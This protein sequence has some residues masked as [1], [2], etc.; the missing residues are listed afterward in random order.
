[1]LSLPRACAAFCGSVGSSKRREYT[2]IGNIV[3]L[4]ARLMQNS[5]DDILCEKNT[6]YNARDHIAFR[7]D[8]QPRRL[9]GF[10]ELVPVFRP[11]GRV[12]SSTLSESF[13][14]R[15]PERRSLAE[16]LHNLIRGGHGRTVFIEGDAGIG[17]TRLALHL[18]LKAAAQ[19]V[20]V[21][22][23]DGNF[24]SRSSPYY[25]WR[26]VFARIFSPDNTFTTHD[27]RTIGMEQAIAEDPEMAPLLPLLNQI[28]PKE[29]PD[30]P[31][32]ASLSP[33]V[34]ADN[35]RLFMIAVL[36]KYIEL[37]S[38]RVL[39]IFDDAHF[40][41]SSSIALCR[42]LH[43]HLSDVLLLLVTRTLK[44]PKGSNL[45]SLLRD[46][47]C[48]HLL[49]SGLNDTDAYEFLRHKLRVPF[50]PE[51]IQQVFHDRACGNPLFIEELANS[52][53]QRGL[54]RTQGD[55]RFFAPDVEDL[56]HLELPH[57]IR[58][59]VLSRIDQLR[60]PESNI[61]KFASVI[62]RVFDPQI[63]EA[64]HPIEEERP[65]I[66]ENLIHLDEL[67][68]T[69]A[70]PSGTK[71]L[72]VFRHALFQEIAY[73]LLPPDHRRYLHLRISEWY[74]NTYEDPEP[75][76]PVLAFHFSRGEN[77]DK[78][79]HYLEKAGK[80]AF[81]NGA[82]QE[83]ARY[84]EGVIETDLKRAESAD[85]ETRA[86]WEYQLGEAN[87]G[88]GHHSR[89]R[90]NLL[91]CLSLLSSPF[92]RTLVGMINKF[93]LQVFTHA[94][95]T[96]KARLSGPLVASTGDRTLLLLR[97]FQRLT[98]SF[99]FSNKAIHTLLGTFLS[100][101]L[102]QRLGPSPELCVDYADASLCSG[103]IGFH[104]LANYY[105]IQASETAASIQEESSRAWVLMVSHGLYRI[106]IGQWD[107]A[108]TALTEARDIYHRL[109][110]RRRHAE[111]L[112]LLAVTHFHKGRY[113]KSLELWDEVHRGARLRGDPQNL[114]WGLVGRLENLLRTGDM[115]PVAS[116]VQD[117]EEQ[118]ESKFGISN[119]ERVWAAGSLALSHH[120]LGNK[121]RALDAAS[122][123]VDAINTLTVPMTIYILEG[124]SSTL[125]YL[126]RVRGI[127]GGR[128]AGDPLAVLTRRA[129][130]GM[131]ALEWA[132]PVSRPRVSLWRGLYHWNKGSTGKAR[133]LWRRSLA[134]AERLDMP[135]DIALAHQEL[136][137]H[138]PADD[139]Q[140]DFHLR[141]AQALLESI[142]AVFLP[143]T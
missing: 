49:L 75:Y 77:H 138:M 119:V 81:D 103:L 27:G 113:Q 114:L 52:L 2:L 61:V 3:N 28:L 36:K 74:E 48:E 68:I 97:A 95:S 40:L 38:Q 96:F 107:R 5:R 124:C 42:L 1:M 140:R 20:V 69:P 98:Q 112:S 100:L 53:L 6:L 30:T 54:V 67:G 15:K 94:W 21:F 43:R 118:L 50:I 90:E 34:R 128:R 76:Y 110:D 105:A 85:I 133:R 63:L 32:T 120:M 82:Y 87:C 58:G 131:S 23:S 44:E 13:I 62:G 11:I 33:D 84:F 141:Q 136:G 89:G 115:A 121:K 130:K 132:F 111:A 65:L 17:K 129:M 8:L 59:V 92:P 45:R 99:Y 134:L 56:D 24:V 80:Q 41:D 143:L 70:Q 66:A 25:I 29:I 104:R 71:R 14:G 127:E 46:D 126:L 60:V 26:P 19:G 55:N 88:L 125:E 10:S 9:K 39:I 78:A 122:K 47:R 137:S 35:T 109:L 31:L 86:S 106:G 108:Y 123:G 93:I 117:I 116:L 79:I 139:E 135:Y 16:C 57:T 72:Y 142:G 73:S 91:Q 64:I 22:T 102:S 101:N 12:E 18:A 37:Y 83:A 4:A 7:T 51:P